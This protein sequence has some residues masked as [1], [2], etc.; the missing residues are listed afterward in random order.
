MESVSAR[1][2]QVSS[3]IG[4]I[5]VCDKTPPNN[6]IITFLRSE[7]E[8]F[9]EKYGNDVLYIMNYNKYEIIGKISKCNVPIEYI[10]KN[11]DIPMYFLDIIYNK[12]F[13]T[14]SLMSV[15]IYFTLD[16]E[17]KNMIIQNQTTKGSYNFEISINEYIRTEN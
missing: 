17:L 11:L 2:Q 6:E 14:G 10:Q 3:T 13:V 4:K 7:N 12:T 1:I 5:K 16:E 8:L 9:N 15:Y